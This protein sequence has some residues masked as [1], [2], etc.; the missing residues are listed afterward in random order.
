VEVGK[1]DFAAL[2]RVL[3]EAGVKPE[4]DANEVDGL[5]AAV[6]PAVGVPDELLGFF[7][8][9]YSASNVA[10]A[11]GKPEFALLD[12]VL[13]PGYPEEKAL[14]IVRAFASECRRY[15]VKLVGGHTGRYEGAEYP[16]A[17]STVLGRRAK[18]RRAPEE[19]DEVYLVGVVGAEAAWLAGAEVEV[20]ELTPLPKA[21]KLHGAE[22]LKLLHDVSEGGLLGALLE[23]S[24]FYRRVLSVERGRVPIHPRA[25]KLEEPL[26][27]P[28]YGALVAVAEEGSR[29]EDFCVREAVECRLIGWV[30]TLPLSTLS[31]RR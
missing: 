15:S 8:F 25:P 13:P 29:L 3:E 24:A 5:L 17:S 6:N 14:S 22:R 4:L 2:R 16:I 9:H 1:L 7:A 12:L 30:G 23:V 19:G 10:V 28:S 31:T 26:S 18:A 21:L 27:L 11:F 20:E